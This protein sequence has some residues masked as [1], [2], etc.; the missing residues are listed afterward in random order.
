[1]TENKRTALG[2]GLSAL[3]PESSADSDLTPTEGSV[4]VPLA[5]IRIAEHQPRTLFDEEKISRL[6]ESIQSDGLL[7]P[8]VVRRVGAASFVIIAGERRYRASRRAGLT[9][10]P[11]FIRD[12]DDHVAYELALVEN[13]QRENLNPIEE[14]EAYNYL[15]KERGLSHEAI[16]QRVGRERVT[17]TNAMR[18]LK[19]TPEVRELVE[20]GQLTAGHAR[21]VLMAPRSQQTGLANRAISEA[22]SVRQTERA[23]KALKNESATPRNPTTDEKKSAAHLAVETQL[24][25]ALGAPVQLVQKDG[26]GHIEVRFHT[27]EEL[28]RLIDLLC[29]L[30]GR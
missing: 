10:V 12:I 3:I 16:A 19:L 24:R 18:L 9:E 26:K 1:M 4:T 14:A 21:A 2:R 29:V 5:N 28:E 30:E 6:A 27:L 11:V 15:S 23:A 20:L 17:V 7:Q 13:V 25:G 22:W 8:I